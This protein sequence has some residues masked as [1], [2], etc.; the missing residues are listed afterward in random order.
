MTGRL[1]ACRLIGAGPHE[2]EQ[3][4]DAIVVREAQERAGGLES[5]PGVPER[6]VGRR[7]ERRAR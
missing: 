6:A 5:D 1:L 4:G 3:V 2:V 7:A